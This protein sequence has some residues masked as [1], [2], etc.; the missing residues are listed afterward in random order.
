VTQ[1]LPVRGKR[2]CR[3]PN[4]GG[5]VP[6]TWSVYCSACRHRDQRHG[7]PSQRGVSHTAY[8]Y[9]LAHIKSGIT[10]LPHHLRQELELRIAKR[11]A[12]LAE[13]CVG[14][15]APG[16]EV[17]ALGRRVMYRT[18]GAFLARALNSEHCLP[19]DLVLDTMARALHWQARP[20]VWLSDRA[21][22]TMAL[23]RLQSIAKVRLAVEWSGRQNRY[24]RRRNQKLAVQAAVLAGAWWMEAVAEL[25]PLVRATA[26]RLDRIR[27]DE[28]QKA[29]DLTKLI[30]EAG[31]VPPPPRRS[32]SEAQRARWA[33]VSKEERKANTAAAR[34]MSVKRRLQRLQ[35]KG[36]S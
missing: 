22:K 8:A 34:A 2:V 20:N 26:T 29:S 15:T 9:Q 6:A 18:A 31:D 12:V 5:L 11:V 36:R 27:K 32:Y 28:A 17:D 10:R 3:S 4:C 13:F 19:V 16:S 24:V 14:L 33:K 1:I 30:I 7:H 23:M 21:F 25:F 35:M